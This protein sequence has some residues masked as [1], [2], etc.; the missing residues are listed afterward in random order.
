MWANRWRWQP[1]REEINKHSVWCNG[2]I[3]DGDKSIVT[4]ALCPSIQAHIRLTTVLT[5]GLRDRSRSAQ[6]SEANF[7]GVTGTPLEFHCASGLVDP[8]RRP[9]DFVSLQDS[10]RHPQRGGFCTGQAG[11]RQAL[12]AIGLGAGFASG[13]RMLRG[14]CRVRLGR[15][16][17]PLDL[18]RL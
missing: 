9:Q 14:G 7:L 4:S 16:S 5:Q 2:I 11:V 15:W 12:V 13:V 1:K 8:S 17:L 18:S 10:V 3:H 6:Q